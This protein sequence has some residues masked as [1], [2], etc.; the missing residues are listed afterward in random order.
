MVPEESQNGSSS[1]RN[2]LEATKWH[3]MAPENGFCKTPPSLLELPGGPEGPR[4]SIKN[5]LFA[6]KC[7]PDV[8]FLT[9]FVQISDLF[10]FFQVFVSIL[11]QKSKKT[12]WKHQGI[13]SHH[14]LFFWTWRPSR[15]VAFYDTKA[16]FSF[17]F[18]LYFFL[19]ETS[20]NDPKLKSHSFPQKTLKSGSRGCVL[21][22]KM[23]LN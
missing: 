10:D 16:T 23:I 22:P 18:I 7:V 17:F 2:A 5:R 15:N 12:W 14:R 19:K 1:E 8:L 13:F 20:K 4:K 6:K 11:R 9:F 21:G 3:Q